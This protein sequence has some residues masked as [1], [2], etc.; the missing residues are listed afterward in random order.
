MPLRRAAGVLLC[1]VLAGCGMYGPVADVR[2]A[3]QRVDVAQSQRPDP[4]WTV[5]APGPLAGGLRQADVLVIA[6]MTLPS[7]L[8]VAIEAADGVRAAELL[9]V[10]SVPLGERAIT[11]AAVDPDGFRRFSSPLTAR[12]GAVWRSVA[13]GEVA[14]THQIGRSLGL[15]LGGQ[16]GLRAGR[17]EVP[18][19]VGAY[20]S[21]VA[22]LDAV[23]NYRRG[24]QLGMTPDNA[25][26]LSVRGPDAV[27]AVE[28]AVGKRAT[29]VPMTTGPAGRQLAYLSGG[30]VAEAVGSFRYQYFPDGTVRPDQ[31]W[32]ASNIRT[33]SVPVLGRVTCHRVMLPQ[34]RSALAEVESRGLADTID[35]G[36]YGGCYVPRFIGRSAANGLSLHTWGIALDLNVSGN[37]RGTTGE[38]DREVVRI[39]KRWGFAWGGDWQWTDPMHFELA[40]LV[41]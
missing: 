35:A 30:A 18:L 20:A 29:V 13:A 16:L 10:A 37:Q 8:R 23:V 38:I 28:A 22:G 9:S 7:R 36:D 1:G 41:R 24:E 15:P 25:L 34:L 5:P 6:R 3:G 40:A 11:V 2:S 32:V 26:L 27:R 33:E 17:A 19:R 21:A 4:S 39:F 12:S 14:L 31:R